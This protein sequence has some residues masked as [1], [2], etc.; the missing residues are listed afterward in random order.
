MSA[1]VPDFPTFQRLAGQAD[2]VPVYRQLISDTLTPVSAYCRIQKGECAFLFESV[3]GGERIGRYSFLGA[4]PFL[5][6]DAFGNRV[7]ISRP[8][9]RATRD[10]ADPLRELESLLAGYR[11]DHMRGLP[12]FCGGAVGYA[13]YD[14]V[15]YTE[16]LP[17]APHDDRGLPDLSFAFYDRMVI[18]DHINKTILVVAHARTKAGDLRAQY[19]AACRRIDETCAQL[20]LG[21][22]D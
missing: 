9:G 17:N 8:E 15:R 5:Q 19:G 7:V 12:R 22:D 6:M 3:V 20:Q 21:K 1:Y 18:F 13:G 4:D 14:V 10:V 11:A 16:K 2:L